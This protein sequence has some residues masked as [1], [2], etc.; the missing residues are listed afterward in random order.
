MNSSTVVK[1]GCL[2]ELFEAQVDINPSKL[3]LLCGSKSMSYQDLE[4]RSN[5]LAHYLRSFGMKSGKFV[6]IYLRRSEQHIIAILAILKSGAAYVPIDI[7]FP[8]ERVRHIV[9]DANVSIL[10]TEQNLSKQVLSFE[11]G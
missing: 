8:I 9:K 1:T 6:G 10:I 11:R 5:Q 4:Y 3:A 7:N 2:H